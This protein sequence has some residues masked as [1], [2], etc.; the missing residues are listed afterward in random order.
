MVG[1]L[2]DFRKRGNRVTMFLDDGEQRIELQMFKDSFDNLKH[3]IEN[4]K[5]RIVKGQLRWDDFIDGWRI[6]VSDMADI[7]RVVENRASHLLIHWDASDEHPLA[8]AELEALL[9]PCRPGRCAVSVHYTTAVATARI[10][11]GDSWGVRPTAE[12]RDKLT[13]VFGLHGFAFYGDTQRQA[14]VS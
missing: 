13:S 12:L 7:D 5:V 8:V 1:L 2:T 6:A 10:K 3:L 9:Q 14:T 4:Y 11:L